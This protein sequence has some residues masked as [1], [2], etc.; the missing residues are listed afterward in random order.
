MNAPLVRPSHENDVPALRSIYGWNVEH[1]TGTFET[2]APDLTEMRRRW[3]AVQ[4]L[5]LPWLVVEVGNTVLG[6]AYA[7]L[8]RTRQAWHW[9]L[10]DSIYLAPQAQ[11]RGL[12]VLLLSELIAR[13]TAI[14]ARQMLA[15]IGDADNR[16][17][18]ALHRRCGFRDAGL[19]RAVGWKHGRWLDCVLMQRALG[20]GDDIPPGPTRSIP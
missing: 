2:E 5:A 3:Q 14:G 12:G 20:C 17:S 1:G 4:D 11:R 8:F 7:N 19:M 18:I 16:G 15:V 9:T 10:E 6:Y 13:C